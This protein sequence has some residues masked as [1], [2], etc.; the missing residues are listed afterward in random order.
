MATIKNERDLL[1]Q[2][3]SPR[4]TPIPIQIAEVAGLTD[5]LDNITNIA[6]TAGKGISLTAS[7]NMFNNS[8][9]GYASPSYITLTAVLKGISGTPSWTVLAGS[10]NIS[11]SGTT[12][13]VDGNTVAG[14]SVTIGVSLGIY[15]AQYTIIRLGALSL[16]QTV[17]L[18]TQVTGQLNTGNITGLGA[19]ATL[20]TIDLNT[21]TVGALNGLTQVNN[22]GTLA[23]ANAIAANQIGAGTLAAGVIYA[24]AINADNITSGTITGRTIRT[25]ASGARYELSGVTLKGYDSGG[26]ARITT[27]LAD[28]TIYAVSV[29]GLA[30]WGIAPGTSSGV[31]GD[32]NS[33]AGVTGQSIY[34]VGGHFV[35]GLGAA[36]LRLEP[37]GTYP[38]PRV[39]G[40]IAYIGGWLCFCNGTDWYQSNGTK[41]T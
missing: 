23:Y 19:L 31:K 41:V 12:C 35:G 5:A 29:G 28:G 1:L 34:G 11:A 24:G 39:A 13:S 15:S 21:Q 38:S 37:S 22:L 18:A 40:D 7:A 32:S 14:S 8:T 6:V 25:A 17:S 3:D 36:P 4:F 2:M 9:G 30:V 26:S 20:N 33:G 27:N 16:Q 10:A